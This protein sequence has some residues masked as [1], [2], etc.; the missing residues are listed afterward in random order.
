MTFDEAL[1]VISKKKIH[2]PKGEFE[3]TSAYEQR[4][5]ILNDEKELVITV[6][7]FSDGLK[8]DTD[9]QIFKIYPYAFLNYRN[10]DLNLNL[11]FLEK[12]K[13]NISDKRNLY[14]VYP[15]IIK[16]M[17]TYQAQNSFG[18]KSKIT[19]IHYFE[20]AVFDRK[21]TLFEGLFYNTY[22]ETKIGEIS[23]PIGSAS[24]FKEKA[25]A[26]FVLVP[27]APYLETGSYQHRAPT[28]PD[29]YDIQV[30]ATILMADIRCALIIDSENSVIA[31]YKT[32]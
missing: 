27:K 6:P 21:T 7:I 3:T 28:I 12:G 15:Q 11:F 25:K 20:K 5:S 29:P 19:K 23:V 2:S 8:Y 13:Y 9:N 16:N 1:A 14:F 18:A 26:A 30:N 32:R 10:S 22:N 31:A 24:D 17:G 4:S